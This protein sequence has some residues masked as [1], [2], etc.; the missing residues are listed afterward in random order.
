MAVSGD[1]DALVYDK[2]RLA[3][4]PGKMC[5]SCSEK[6]CADD[7]VIKHILNIIYFSRRTRGLYE[8]RSCII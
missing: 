4:F 5:K 6:A 2:D 1:M 7:E 3:G 8:T